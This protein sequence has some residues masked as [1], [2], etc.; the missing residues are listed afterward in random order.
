MLHRPARASR[1]CSGDLSRE[2][3]LA[4][5]VDP[6]KTAKL[7]EFYVRNVWPLQRRVVGRR[8]HRRCSTCGASERM[9]PLD[10]RGS[11]SE[12]DARSRQG[13]PQQRARDPALEAELA[14]IFAAAQGTG[15]GDHDAL[16]MFSGGKDSS[17]L[18]RRLRDEPRGC[19]C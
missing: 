4:Q 15:R 3:R 9:L 1:S 7:F 17:Y 5:D 12:C 10:A 8:I 16:V 13:A 18:V 2:D 14:K 6:V 19:G 11:C